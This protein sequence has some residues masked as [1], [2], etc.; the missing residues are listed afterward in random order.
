MGSSDPRPHLSLT[1][2]GLAPR[3]GEEQ[4]AAEQEAA[5]QDQHEARGARCSHSATKRRGTV[6]GRGLGAALGGNLWSDP[7]GLPLLLPPNLTAT[8]SQRLAWLRGD[9]KPL[10]EREDRRPHRAERPQV[11]SRPEG[12]SGRMAA[13]VGTEPESLNRRTL[14]QRSKQVP[15]MSPSRSLHRGQ[16]AW[17]EPSPTPLGD[18]CPLSQAEVGR[19]QWE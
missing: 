11:P 12:E 14:R 6:R 4:E 2:E 10:P 17:R 1:P 19:T 8:G 16:R 15:S 5:G 3:E 18:T 7:C 13:A 9:P